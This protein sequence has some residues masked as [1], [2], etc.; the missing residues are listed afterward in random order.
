MG[1]LCG[2]RWVA[3]QFRHPPSTVKHPDS[4]VTTSP[5]DP[6]SYLTTAGKRS[7]GK[8]TPSKFSR[9]LQPSL[10]SAKEVRSLEASHRS[11]V[12]EPLP[13]SRTLQDGNPPLH[14]GGN[15][16][17]RLGDIH[18]P[19]GCLLSYSNSSVIPEVPPILGRYER[20]PVPG[21]P[22]WAFSG[23]KG[24]LQNYGSGRGSR[25]QLRSPYPP[26]FRRLVGQEPNPEPTPGRYGVGYQAYTGFGP[27]NK[28][29]EVRADTLPGFCIR[30]DAIHNI[31]EQGLCPRTAYL[32]YPQPG[33]GFSQPTQFVGPTHSLF[34]R[35]LECGLRFD[36]PG[37]STSSSLAI[38]VP[39]SV[40][41][42]KE[43]TGGQDSFVQS[44]P[45]T[46][47][48]VE[49]NRSFCWGPYQH[50]GTTSFSFLGCQPTWLGGSPRTIGAHSVGEMVQSG[51][52]LAH[53]CAGNGGGS[54]VSSTFPILSVERN[55]DAIDRQHNGSVIHTPSRG[56]SVTNPVCGDL[57]TVNLVSGPEHYLAGSSPPRSAEC[58]SRSPIQ[59]LPSSTGGMGAQTGSSPRNFRT[60]RDSPSRPL[61]HQVQCPSPPVCLAN[62]RPQ[63]MG[64]RRHVS[65][66]GPSLRICVPAVHTDT[67]DPEQN[68]F[69]RV[70]DDFDS[71]VV[72]SEVLVQ[73]STSPTHGLSASTPPVRDSSV[74][75]SRENQA[76]QPVNSPSSRLEI[77]R[78]AVKEANFS[79]QVASH[80][81]ESRRSSTAKIY[82]S[83]WTIFCDWCS[84][85]QVDSSSPSVQNIAE[86]LT[87]LFDE[88]E[89]SVSTIKGYRSMLSNT[90]KLVEDAANPGSDPVISELIRSFELKRPVSRSLWPKWDL[91]A[92]LVSLTK[93]PFEPLAGASL[94]FLSWKTAFL[95]AFASAKR[96]SELHALSIEPGQF[97]FNRDGSLSLSFQPGFLAKNQL[98]SVVPPPL[99]IPSLSAV[100]GRSDHDRYLCPVRAIKFYLKA[101]ESLRVNR[102]RLFIPL[103]GS[104]EISAATISRWIGSAIKFAFQNLSDDEI[105]SLQIR[106]HELRALSSSWAFLNHTPLEEVLRAAFWRSETTFS[107]FYLR[108]LATQKD[109]LNQL[110]PLVAAQRVVSRD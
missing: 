71:A 67:G 7:G 51:S 26:V 44:V 76:P 61:R 58:H 95:L 16:T 38:L 2:I 34:T 92:V 91:S 19:D 103:K 83:K 99:I 50:R 18:R 108:S 9:L 22:L 15:P 40:E 72:A 78:R 48:V 73:R 90:L 20:V 66:L 87:F 37:S 54:S 10:S 17:L 68:S 32:Q 14:S 41:P 4:L 30:R 52:Q 28:S 59:I 6:S 81:S 96:R 36:S 100:C 75:V 98:P 3:P 13:P 47:A 42:S 93:H 39:K 8:G 102:S 55:S 23:P 64:S 84:G 63:G 101:T 5:R 53:Q 65:K 110:G 88:K 106:P 62:V 86:F 49:G 27:D 82:Q 70:L 56:H 25:S 79:E 94:K 1:P 80:V 105:Q 33:I 77:V 109:N 43:P 45:T 107:S 104:K 97:R 89:L 11:V 24:I 85:Q 46:P 12:S 60:I 57:E 74:S 31:P 21:A 35:G 29:G 69:V